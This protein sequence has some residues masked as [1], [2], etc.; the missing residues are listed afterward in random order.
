MGVQQFDRSFAQLTI[1]IAEVQQMWTG[2]LWLEG[3]VYFRDSRQL[4]WS[5]IPRQRIM[6]LTDAGSW[7]CWGARI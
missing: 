7:V 1:G 2:G 4:L 3:P 6:R 5:D